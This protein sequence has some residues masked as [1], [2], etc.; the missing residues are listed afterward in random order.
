M[1]M[2]CGLGR[3]NLEKK[4][5][6]LQRFCAQFTGDC[7]TGRYCM[8]VVRRKWIRAQTWSSKRKCGPKIYA[9]QTELCFY[10]IQ[11]FSILGLTCFL[12]SLQ[13]GNIVCRFSHYMNIFSH[14]GEQ[15][16]CC[17]NKSLFIYMP[18]WFSNDWKWQKLS[19][20]MRCKCI[21]IGFIARLIMF[22]VLYDWLCW[23]K[24]RFCYQVCDIQLWSFLMCPLPLFFLTCHREIMRHLWCSEATDLR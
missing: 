3:V 12:R 18:E 2:G 20:I 17:V 8:T 7:V 19:E 23:P 1:K 4:R 24:S 9:F 13:N 15:L 21:S 16:D 14:P 22:C 10:P 11:L 5:F 6:D